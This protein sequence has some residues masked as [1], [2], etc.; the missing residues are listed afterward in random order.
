MEKLC[1]A[2]EALHAAVGVIDAAAKAN[3][4]ADVQRAFG[5]YYAKL[6]VYRG[7]ARG[8]AGAPNI[9]GLLLRADRL[10]RYTD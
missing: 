3:V 1:S 6:D 10:Q 9:E 5:D 4:P 8:V 2:A 7:A